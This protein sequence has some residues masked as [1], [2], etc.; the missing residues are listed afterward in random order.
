MLRMLDAV[1]L[2]LVGTT[3]A[4]PLR[5]AVVR[6][7]DPRIGPWRYVLGYLACVGKKP[8]IVSNHGYEFTGCIA[9]GC[10]PVVG[11]RENC[12]CKKMSSTRVTQLSNASFGR[13]IATIILHDNFEIFVVLSHQCRQTMPQSIG[14]LKSGDD[15]GKLRSQF[16][17]PTPLQKDYCGKLLGSKLCQD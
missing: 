1:L 9:K 11:H 15:N 4:F 3:S 10:F 2:L 16:R 8:V 17:S 5:V 6:W 14:A 13:W 12:A 7:A